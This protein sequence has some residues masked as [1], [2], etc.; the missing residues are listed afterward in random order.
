[1]AKR[2]EPPR[3][4][5]GARAAAGGSIA[6]ALGALVTLL[7][8]W[9][10]KKNDPYLD[11]VGVRTVCYGETAVKMRRYSDAECLVM[12]DRRAQQF[13]EAVRRRNPRIT[14]DPY[15][16]AAHASLAYNVGVSTYNRSSVALLYERGREREACD[17]I[18][19]YRL[20]GGRVLRG[21]VLRR[22]G[23]AARLGE[24][25]LCKWEMPAP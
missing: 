3:R 15:Q 14:E 24:I 12:L 10:G 17:A 4:S 13:L 11:S 20:A 22:Q 19:R 6:I 2:G 18:G 25:E 16:W 8:V 5:R 21:L 7:P 9:E 23:D 1:M